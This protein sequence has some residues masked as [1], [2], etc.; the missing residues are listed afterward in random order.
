[1]GAADRQGADVVRA[2]LQGGA[3]VARKGAG[4][5]TA[6]HAAAGAGRLDNVELLL[7]AGAMV[8]ARTTRGWTALHSAVHRGDLPM[9]RRLIAAG[10]DVSR[11]RTELLELARSAKSPDVEKAIRDAP[12]TPKK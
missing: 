2:L 4:N 5:A 7:A 6:L 11:D 3:A 8:T 12:A 9:A 1:A 10:A